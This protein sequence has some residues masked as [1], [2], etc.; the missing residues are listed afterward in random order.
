M[1]APLVAAAGYEVRFCSDNDADA[2]LVIHL[3]GD[4]VAGSARHQIALTKGPDGGVAVDRYDRTTL[5][6]LVST[7]GRRP[8]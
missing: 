4:E 7:A 3:D 5:H 1:L 8:A 6:K 2:D